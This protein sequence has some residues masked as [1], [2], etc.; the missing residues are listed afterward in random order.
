LLTVCE[1]GNLLILGSKHWR[2]IYM[3]RVFVNV[4]QY[5]SDIIDSI[6]IYMTIIFNIVY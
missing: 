1:Q 2:Y 5:W 6:I 3:F 4:N